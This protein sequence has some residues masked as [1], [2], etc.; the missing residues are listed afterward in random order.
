MAKNRIEKGILEIINS[1]SIFLVD[2]IKY[3][4]LSNHIA[5]RLNI[6]HE[7]PQAFLIKNGMVVWSASHNAISVKAL[8]SY[9]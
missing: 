5:N 2:L 7:S 6:K 4:D 8:E 3:R 9:L 1:S